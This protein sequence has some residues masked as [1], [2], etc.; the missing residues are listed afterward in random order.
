M[1]IAGSYLLWPLTHS[2]LEILPT[3]MEASCCTLCSLLIHMQNIS[4]W[5]S[6]ICR[7]RNFEILGSAVL[8]FTFCFLFYTFFSLFLPHF[9][10]SCWAFSRL[11]FGGKSFRK[12]FRISGSDERKGRWV[13]EK[14]FHGNLQVN[15]TWFNVKTD[16]ITSSRKEV[17][18]H[19]WLWAAQ[20]RMG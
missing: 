16:D 12:A 13:V 8:T 2:P 4:L 18:L 15:V 17:D 20:G 14:D 7:K 1:S 9:F 11:H 19:G 6:G 5:S 3:C 10:L